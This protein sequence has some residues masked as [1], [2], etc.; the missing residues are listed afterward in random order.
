M[1]LGAGYERLQ[2][3]VKSLGIA[4]RIHWTGALPHEK[5]FEYI[6]HFD[7][8]VLPGTLATG[9][10]IKLFEYAAVAR[11]I[12]APNLPNLRTWF[13][14]DEIY[15]VPP[16]DVEAL[17][18]VIKGLAA[19][20]EYARAMGKRAQRRVQEYIWERIVAKILETAGYPVSR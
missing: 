6:S 15:F 9:A 2:A 11:P 13:S 3:L 12:I 18:D 20:P 14:E 10:P 17:V 8:A 7:I 19:T 5:A 4:K 1:G 16:E